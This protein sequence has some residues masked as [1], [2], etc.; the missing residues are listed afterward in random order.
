MNVVNGTQMF[1]L[2]LKTTRY[3]LPNTIR[4]PAIRDT[5]EDE[6][7]FGGIVIPTSDDY[8]DDFDLSDQSDG[9]MSNT[10]VNFMNSIILP[11]KNDVS[12]TDNIA[13]IDIAFN[14]GPVRDGIIKHYTLSL[15][16]IQY[17]PY[18]PLQ[19]LSDHIL[20]QQWMQNIHSTVHEHLNT[21]DRKV[22]KGQKEENLIKEIIVSSSS[23]TS[24]RDMN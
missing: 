24:A 19:G 16:P 18:L 4:N 12:D 7:K 3:T 1:T 6:Q 10:F 23:I 5:K 17:N 14:L 13:T 15:I 11:S 2:T 22:S 9:N 8:S 21:N 20:F